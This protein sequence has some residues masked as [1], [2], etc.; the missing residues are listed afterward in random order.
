MCIHIQTWEESLTRAS[1]F[2][3]KTRFLSVFPNNLAPMGIMQKGWLI[4]LLG[5][6]RNN[7]DREGGRSGAGTVIW[8]QIH[9]S[10]FKK[11]FDFTC[12]SN[13]NNCKGKNQDTYFLEPDVELYGRSTGSDS[14]DDNLLCTHDNVPTN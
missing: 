2:T 9:L 6:T 8:K 14:I 13:S 7:P 4:P 1:F 5:W 10:N 11:K 3:T 12:F